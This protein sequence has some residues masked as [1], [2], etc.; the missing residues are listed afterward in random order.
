MG[1][2]RGRWGELVDR[3]HVRSG[4]AKVNMVLLGLD[5]SGLERLDSLFVNWTSV[6]E[7]V[8]IM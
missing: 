2:S 7:G 4:V 1:N 3:E 5:R 8:A 6:G